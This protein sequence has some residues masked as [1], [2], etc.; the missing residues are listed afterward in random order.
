VQRDEV[1]AAKEM[2]P[3]SKWLDET[4]AAVYLNTSQRF[5]RRLVQERRIPFHRVGKFIRIAPKDLDAFVQAGR[6]EA[7][8]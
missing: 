2:R 6:I 4:Q 8:R 1:E 3:R 7:Q 5:V